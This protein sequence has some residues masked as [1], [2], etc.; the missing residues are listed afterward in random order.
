[1]AVL[2]LALVGCVEIS[3][4]RVYAGRRLDL[5][6]DTEFDIQQFAELGFFGCVIEKIFRDNFKGGCQN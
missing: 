2:Q 5:V 6:L 1:L 3:A 4:H